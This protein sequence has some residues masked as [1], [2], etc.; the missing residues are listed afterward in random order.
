MIRVPR[1]APT[2]SPRLRDIAWAAGFLEGEGSFSRT[3]NG[4]IRIDAGQVGTWPLELLLTWFGG[5]IYDAHEPSRNYNIRRWYLGGERARGLALTIYP[6][7][8]P[9]RRGQIKAALDR[10]V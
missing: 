6:L 5:R 4:T 1:D 7:M 8:S 10:R 9:R 3:G 2:K